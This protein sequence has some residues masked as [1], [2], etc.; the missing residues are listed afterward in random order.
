[1]SETD[2][3]KRQ[4]ADQQ[5]VISTYVEY[6]VKLLAKID[7]LKGVIAELKNTVPGLGLGEK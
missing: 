3:L 6:N 2:D 4:L 5:L 7:Q 1:M